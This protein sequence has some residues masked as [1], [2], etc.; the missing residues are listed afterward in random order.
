MQYYCVLYHMQSHAIVKC[1]NGLKLDCRI[2][3]ENDL[4]WLPF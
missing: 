4:W 2:K 1:G 3:S